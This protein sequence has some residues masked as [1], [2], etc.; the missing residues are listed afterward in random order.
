M[1]YNL[2]KQK[3]HDV[4]YSESAIF[5]SHKPQTAGKKTRQLLSVIVPVYNEEDVLE[6]C[7]QRLN[8][9]ADKLAINTEIIYINDGSS[10]NTLALLNEMQK[11]NSRIAVI[12]LSR[13]FGKE[14]AMTAGLD[15]AQGDAV[16]II[17]AD[18]QDPPELI[19]EMLAQWQQGYDIVYMKRASRDG[20][21][22]FKKISATAFYRVIN[23][24]SHIEIPEGVGD[25]RLLNRRAVDSLCQLRESNRFM[26]GMFCWLGF[27]QK[28]L[29]YNRE[30]RAS[31][32][33]KWNYLA[34]WDLAV[35]GITAF[36]TTPLKLAGYAG[37]ICVTLSIF[38]S[39]WL[40]AQFLI[41]D[42]GVSSHILLMLGLL[43]FAGIQMLALGVLGEYLG[44]M[45]IETKHR[46]LY[47]VN[48][49][50]P[51]TDSDDIS[52]ATQVHDC[53]KHLS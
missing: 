26:K 47:L 10:D 18:L 43:F 22:W 29:V 9:V 7:Q 23:R 16:I 52:I 3:E 11:N 31:G 30:E 41:F 13:N 34:L 35:D 38:A 28:E 32:T 39:V 19:P 14:I 24:I 49:W 37:G 51:C 53:E 21:S 20:E 36:S 50:A 2:N 8:A 27:K 46:P 25:F 33:S 48:D 40:G 6:Q 45:Y 15:Y 17:D 12:D 1:N 44:R 42:A 5:Y 4:S